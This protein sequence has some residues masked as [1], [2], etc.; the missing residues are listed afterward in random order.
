LPA[1]HRRLHSVQNRAQAELKRRV[2]SD[3][4]VAME[5]RLIRISDDALMQPS[6]IA[7]A[8]SRKFRCDEADIRSRVGG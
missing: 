1:I 8:M 2:D 5:T 4:M 3:P 7:R 6:S